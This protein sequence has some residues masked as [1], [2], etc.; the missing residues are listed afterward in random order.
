MY[1]IAALVTMLVVAIIRLITTTRKLMKEEE[2]RHNFLK[3]ADL[4]ANRLRAAVAGEG[5]VKKDAAYWEAINIL[6]TIPWPDS[7]LN[8]LLLSEYFFDTLI[9]LGRTAKDARTQQHIAEL[10]QQIENGS[11]NRESLNWLCSYQNISPKSEEYRRLDSLLKITEWVRRCTEMMK[12]LQQERTPNSEIGFLNF[13]LQPVDPN[14]SRVQKVL[15]EALPL[16]ETI[17]TKNQGRQKEE[18]AR[19]ASLKATIEPKTTW[20]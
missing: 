18:V 3:Y 20:P 1:I 7:S 16:A 17:L 8:E 12:E 11:G 4:L 14:D 2:N 6:S 13:V 9:V 5:N 19:L 10:R 15:E